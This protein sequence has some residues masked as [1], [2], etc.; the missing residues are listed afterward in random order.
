MEGLV[1]V[2]LEAC[3]TVEKW[4]LVKIA[5]LILLGG[6]IV[7]VSW[8]VMLWLSCFQ[9][10]FLAKCMPI[11]LLHFN[12]QVQ[13]ALTIFRSFLVGS[14]SFD[15]AVL[16]DSHQ[17]LQK[18]SS[19]GLQFC[20][21]MMHYLM[22][23]NSSWGTWKIQKVQSKRPMQFLKSMAWQISGVCCRSLQKQ[24]LLVCDLAAQAESELFF[25][26]Q[27]EGFWN[28]QV[29]TVVNIARAFRMMFLGYVFFPS[30]V[31]RICLR[32]P[33]LLGI[34]CFACFLQ[35]VAYVCGYLLLFVTIFHYLPDCDEFNISTR[36]VHKNRLPSSCRI[37]EEGLHVIHV[38]HWSSQNWTKAHQNWVECRILDWAYE[39]LWVY[40]G[41]VTCGWFI[42]SWTQV[43][44]LVGLRFIFRR[45]KTATF[46]QFLFFWVVMPVVTHIMW[47]NHHHII[48][49]HTNPRAAAYVDRDVQTHALQ[50]IIR[51]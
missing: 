45:G 50:R 32:T 14:S 42:I 49:K 24:T 7:W 28:F 34:C 12:V 20:K 25:A 27:F 10:R 38:P 8:C 35:F 2:N 11:K 17:W 30:P 37:G 29:K 16:M 1:I 40:L 51:G 48:I 46:L 19:T 23:S 15:V 47:V 22:S 5:D 43:V 44:D 21:T 9:V 3:A 18:D 31:S 4:T 41:H 13:A 39:I 6:Y 33:A 26:L 36:L